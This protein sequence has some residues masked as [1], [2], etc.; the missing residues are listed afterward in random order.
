MVKVGGRLKETSEV[1]S[2]VY[3]RRIIAFQD[4]EGNMR[5]WI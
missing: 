1:R 2:Y 3:H 5:R 4:R